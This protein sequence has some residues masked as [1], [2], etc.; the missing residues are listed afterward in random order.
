MGK[1]LVL[2]GGGHA[3]LTT[4]LNIR[5]FIARGHR[6][7]LV[8]PSEVHYYSGMGPGA[9][10]GFYS[11]EQIR[12]PVKEMA[13]SR[14]GAFLR[15]KVTSVDPEDRSLILASGAKLPYDVV[16]FNV[17]SGIRFRALKSE[18][19]PVFP[20]K[21]IENLL[22]AR[23]AVLDTI[24]TGVPEIVAVGGGPA[25]LEV[26]GNVH[27]IVQEQG[28]RA[29]IRVLAGS[30]LLGRF[31]SR[32]R[33]LAVRSLG[34]RAIE[35][36]EGA[37]VKDIRQGSLYLEED[38]TLR[39]DLCFVATG[40]QPPPLFRESNLDVGPDGG[41]LVNEYLQ[42]TSY[43]E[44]FGGGDCISFQP[45][46]LEKV[47]VFAV[48]ENPI[49]YHNLMAAMEEKRLKTFDPGG[50]YLLI[51]N[52]GDGKGILC[53]GPLVVSGKAVFLLK[54]F[55]DLKFMDKFKKAG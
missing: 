24:K 5:N 28:G 20:V 50:G 55:I 27:K 4:I 51:F 16:S 44:V 26:A 39:Y 2:V 53:K 29:S 18:P 11:A 34:R 33:K 1:D 40:V 31:S 22:W 47:G 17:G 48:R 13:E 43:P 46:P 25:A 9:L 7:T 41:L 14:G 12:F 52:T 37:R 30:Q 35:V 49:L 6:V 45:R 3:H 32:A 38:R 8:G 23:Q 54:N 42:S 21:P 15:D 36:I 19:Q 10:G